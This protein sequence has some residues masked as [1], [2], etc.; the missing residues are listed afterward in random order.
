[1]PMN[2]V[3]L[4]HYHLIGD[5][6]HFKRYSSQHSGSKFESKMSL[7]L[8]PSS[9]C[10][11]KTIFLAIPTVQN[12]RRKASS[13]QLTCPFAPDHMGVLT[14]AES[15][16]TGHCCQHPFL[17]AEMARGPQDSGLGKVDRGETESC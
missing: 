6:S 13:I 17:A 14:K 3:V 8:A 2:I 11:S 5:K 12:D 10:K 9:P 4:K 15:L 7:A 1:M 16:V